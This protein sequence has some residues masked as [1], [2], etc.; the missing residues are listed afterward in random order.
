MDGRVSILCTQWVKDHFKGPWEE[1]R[2]RGPELCSVDFHRKFP[3][4]SFWNVR[5]AA[6]DNS[7]WSI[8]ISKDHVFLGANTFDVTCYNSKEILDAYWQRRR[9][10]DTQGT[11]RSDATL[12]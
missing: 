3:I 6:P 10:M 1:P 7:T 8:T 9:V 4:I 5:P 12:K 2:Q 11:Q